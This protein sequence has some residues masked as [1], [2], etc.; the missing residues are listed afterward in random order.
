M[1]ERRRLHARWVVPVA[2]PP[3]EQGTVVIEGERIV[4]VGPTVQAPPGGRDEPLGEAIVTPGLVNAHTHLDLTMLRRAM[5][6]LGFFDWVRTVAAVHREV[7]TDADRLDA[8]LFGIAE[9][10]AN[11]IT[12]FGD[13]APSVAAFDA[14]RLL[15]VRGIAYREVFGPDPA[16]C[17]A[18]LELLKRIVDELR[19][20]ETPLVRIGVSPHAPYSV[21]DELFRAVEQWAAAE[22]LPVAV[23]IAESE[24]ESA[25]VARGEG[26]FAEFL[27]GRGIRVVPRAPSPLALLA[28]NGLVR[29]DVLLIHCARIEGGEVEFVARSGA[30][31]AHCPVSNAA[32]GHAVAPIG[33]LV[34]AGAKVGIGSDSMGSNEAM[35]LFAEARMT[36][37]L[38]SGRRKSFGFF[39]PSAIFRLLTLGGAEA[40]GLDLVTGSLVPGKQADVAIFEWAP[41][42][43]KVLDPCGALLSGELP[44][45]ATG[46]LVAGRDV[47]REGSVIG[48]DPAVRGRVDAATER[49]LEWRR[50]RTAS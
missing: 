4:W 12:C 50:T 2:S 39:T 6:G 8:A 7:L 20:D 17:G 34:S 3:I 43:T 5:F 44:M 21:S 24:A 35:D 33:E 45:R 25:L 36:A 38:Q 32:F 23:H 15:G 19:P 49:V 42:K 41:S 22:Q 18:S 27:R 47:V 14:M 9:G 13:T 26:P 40:L 16:Q 1:S 31:V 28:A 30:G 37:R 46:V 11:G 10:L 48:L 29:R